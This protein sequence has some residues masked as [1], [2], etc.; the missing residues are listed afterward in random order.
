MADGRTL[1]IRCQRCPNVLH[2]EGDFE[3]ADALAMADTHDEQAHPTATV[4]QEGPA[5]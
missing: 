4:K 2:F 5:S 3:I 1:T